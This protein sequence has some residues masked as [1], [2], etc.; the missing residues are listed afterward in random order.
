MEAYGLTHNGK[1][2]RIVIKAFICDAPARQWVKSIIDHCGKFACERCEIKGVRL[3]V[4]PSMIFP[5]L[6]RP[7]RSDE[8]F[9]EQSQP[10]HHNSV[11]PLEVLEINMID[12]FPY[13]WMHLVLLGVFMRLLLIWTGL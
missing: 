1:T 8:S 10:K 5:R 9:R 4:P 11:S 2:Y 3:E 7:L 6:G 13:D 12:H